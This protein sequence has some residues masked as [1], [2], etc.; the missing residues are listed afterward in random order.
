M[1]QSEEDWGEEK[2]AWTVKREIGQTLRTNKIEQDGQEIVDLKEDWKGWRYCF[3][4][5]VKN[6]FRSMQS[7]R[8]CKSKLRSN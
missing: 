5:E 6:F 4:S 3:S 8:R 7:V 2:T 1:A